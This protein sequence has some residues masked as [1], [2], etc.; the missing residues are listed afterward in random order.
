[1]ALSMARIVNS[2]VRWVDPYSRRRALGAMA[3]AD[4]GQQPPSGGWI[5]AQYGALWLGVLAKLFLDYLIAARGGGGAGGGPTS[6]P[7]QPSTP[8]P[9]AGLPSVAVSSVWPVNLS[10]INLV[11]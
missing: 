8:S 6:Q 7:T 4:A 10:I 9:G 11:I 5:A 2:V 1:M 3:Q